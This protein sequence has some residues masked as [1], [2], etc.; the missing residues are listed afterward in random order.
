M[1]KDNFIPIS[2]ELERFNHYLSQSDKIIFSAKFGDGKTCFLNEYFRKF[3]QQYF[4]IKLY[5]VNY[6][7][8]ENKDIFELI[9]R[10][11][12][13]QLLANDVIK[14]ESVIDDALIAQYYLFNNGSDILL[15]ILSDI[16][17]IK[18]PIK[19]IQKVAKHFAKFKEEKQ[20]AQASDKDKIKNYLEDF[21]NAKG[22]YEYD[23]Y[24]ELIVRCIDQ[25]KEKEKRK[26]VLLIEDLD[27]IDPEHI[28]RIL[29][30]LS[31]HIDRPDVY[32]EHIE[33]IPDNKFH[34]DKIITVFHYE[35]VEEIFH[36]FY[37]Q[38]T[39]FDG[40]IQKFTTKKPFIYSLKKLYLEYIINSINDLE[41]AEYIDIFQSLLLK[42]IDDTSYSLRMIVNN[43]N[44]V[45]NEARIDINKDSGYPFLNPFTKF[46]ILCERF[47]IDGIS[48]LQPYYKDQLLFKRLCNFIGANW[49]YVS[50]NSPMVIDKT[51][52]LSWNSLR[53]LD[54][55]PQF[56][57]EIRYLSQTIPIQEVNGKIQ[58]IKSYCLKYI[59][60][61][62]KQ[63]KAQLQEK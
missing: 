60:I 46:I 52:V 20:P 55:M 58:E 51:L 28:F 7:V 11:I 25:I 38:K 49:I 1:G 32:P 34:F 47:E 41:I 15:D 4:C 23:T 29:N 21:S 48:I 31:A 13:I 3:E 43:F 40:Y 6:Q 5:P 42:I 54:K 45:F 36:H 2:D 8:Q 10:D 9:K 12:L 59:N 61:D 18:T 19:I 44:D 56:I 26:V 37:G 30:I 53:G 24:S 63:E 50:H 16:P 62:H 39:D 27:R 57:L 14:T 35:N 33:S 22:I 17:L